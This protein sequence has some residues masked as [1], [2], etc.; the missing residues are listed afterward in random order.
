MFASADQH[1]LFYERGILIE[2]IFHDILSLIG[3][4]MVCGVILSLVPKGQFEASLKLI[5]GVFLTICLLHPLMNFS[6]PSLSDELLPEEAFAP[7]DVFLRGEDFARREL[8]QRI[9]QETKEYILDKADAMN[10]CVSAEVTLSD[11]DIPVPTAVT[12][13][14]SADLSAREALSRILSED[15][16]IS[17]E[18][19][20]WKEM[21]SAK[22]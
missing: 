20:L 6:Y 22:K 9:K 18:N 15:L 1:H 17:K 14:T 7:E 8:C 13:Y 19:Q 21:S 10:I 16:G 2:G 4:A 3:G 11:T 5:C 12:I